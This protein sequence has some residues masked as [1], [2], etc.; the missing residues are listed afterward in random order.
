M[1]Y[2]IM[3]AATLGVF[4]LSHAPKSAMKATDCSQ[5]RQAARVAAM[6]DEVLQF[7]IVVGFGALCFGC[8]YLMAF[9]VTRTRFRNQ[10]IK[11]GAA[12]FDSETGK[13]GWEKSPKKPKGL[14]RGQFLCLPVCRQFAQQAF[15]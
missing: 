14:M 11:R 12:H 5:H 2:N 1:K 8:G 7:I 15:G 9:L 4:D 6:S 3:D 10:M 13:W